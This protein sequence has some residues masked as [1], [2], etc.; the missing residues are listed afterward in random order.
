MVFELLGQ[1][2]FDFLKANQFKPFPIHQIQELGKQ[3]LTSVTCKLINLG[4]SLSL[5]EKN[6]I[7]CGFIY[8]LLIIISFA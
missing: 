5:K 3:L 7:G 1:S 2:V 4:F 6:I 8:F